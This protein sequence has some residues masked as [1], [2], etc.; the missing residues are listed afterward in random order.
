MPIY[1]FACQVCGH[2]CEFFAKS[3]HQHIE[4]Q[5]PSCGS[6]QLQRVLSRPYVARGTT[7]QDRAPHAPAVE[8]RSCPSGTCTTLTL[9]GHS[10]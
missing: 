3:P 6:E 8:N 2:L 1:E 5:C 4:L 10:R 7:G 9:P